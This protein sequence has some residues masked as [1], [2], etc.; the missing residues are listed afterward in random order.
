MGKV[1]PGAISVL[2]GLVPSPQNPAK[3]LAEL[4]AKASDVRTQIGAI[5]DMPYPADPITE[6]EFQGLTYYQV[7][8]IR[9]AQLMGI[10]SLDALEFFTDRRIGKPAQVNLNVNATESYTDFLE[11]IAR[12][13]GEV[14]DVSP[15]NELGI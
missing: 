3:Y 8:L 5:A 13:E 10:G 9:Q 4:K 6:P 15:Q 12:A 1:K 14:I 2:S 11:K 7:G